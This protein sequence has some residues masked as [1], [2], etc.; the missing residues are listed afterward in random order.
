MNELLPERLEQSECRIYKIT[1]SPWSKDF[2]EAEVGCTVVT[3]ETWKKYKI[4]NLTKNKILQKRTKMHYWAVRD[5]HK[6][7]NIEVGENYRAL[8]QNNV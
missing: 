5:I 7:Q 6:N 3:D 1:S 8:P 2:R 4:L